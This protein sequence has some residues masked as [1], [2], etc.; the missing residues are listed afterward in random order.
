[1]TSFVL[2]K[3]GDTVFD[4]SQQITGVVTNINHKTNVAEVLADAPTNE[5]LILC[6]LANLSLIKKGVSAE[7]KGLNK[8]YKLVKEFH[9]AFEHPVANSPVPL[10]LERMINRK[11]WEFEEGIEAIHA[12]SDNV[13][14]FNNAVDK[15]IEGI[16]KARK[17]SLKE[18][19]PKSDLDR[20]VAQAD[21]LV[22]G[23]YFL[24]GDFVEMGIEPDKLLE[25]VQNSNMSKL[26]VNENGDK[27]AKYRESDGKILKS[28]HFFE[29]EPALEV[30]IKRQM[31]N[32]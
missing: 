3:K 21:A 19:F 5:E 30:E 29:P 1:M 27:Y 4:S 9:V 6:K 18:E 16:E 17:K 28:E 12:S 11:S 14:E 7:G 24:Q 32:K 22:D 31:N 23:T 10:T 26:F 15:I 13:D 20:I 8:A 25:I 2:I